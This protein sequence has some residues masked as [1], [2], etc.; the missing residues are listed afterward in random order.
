MDKII[1]RK[2]KQ[3]RERGVEWKMMGK[4]SKSYM[5]F[6]SD[7]GFKFLRESNDLFSFFFI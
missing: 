5:I 2:K 6:F 1:Y 7:S 4:F 3:E